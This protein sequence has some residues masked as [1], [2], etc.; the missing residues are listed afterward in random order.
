MVEKNLEAVKNPH[1]EVLGEFCLSF[2]AYSRCS[3]FTPLHRLPPRWMSV[4]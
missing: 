2:T 3:R 1:D 4:L